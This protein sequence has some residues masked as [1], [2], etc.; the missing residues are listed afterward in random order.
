MWF[1]NV[2]APRRSRPWQPLSQSGASLLEVLIA[3]LVMSFGVT[4]AALLMAAT[5]Q[6]NKTSQ[7]QMVALHLATQI[8]ES[9]RA[10]PDGFMAGNYDQLTTY[11]ANRAAAAIP[12]CASSSA[13]SSSEIAAID[14]AQL[15]NTLRQALPGGDFNVQRRGTYADIW[16]MWQ[17]P[18]TA[19]SLSLGT[20][21]C[22]GDALAGVSESPRCFYLQ[23]AL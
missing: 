5:M 3:L 8:A 7:Y 20:A 2:P 13:C 11:T 22:R 12:A 4:G 6:Y 23:V 14:Q 16:I 15:N 19:A 9:L 17:E 1:H 21:A 18:A 10:N